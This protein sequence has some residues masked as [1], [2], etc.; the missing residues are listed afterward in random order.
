[1]KTDTITK[2]YISDTTVFADV[3]NYFIYGGE[4]VI[5]PEQLEERDPTEIALPY[6]ADG[7]AAP[8]QKFR[9]VQKL[10]AAMTDGSLEYV[11]YGI[12]AQSEIHYAAAVKNNLYDAIGYA[13]QVEE[14]ARSH[15]RAMKQAKADSG[16]EQQKPNAGE[17]LSGFWKTDRLIPSV[18]VML[19]FAPDAWDGPLSLFDMME[20][21]DPRILS[22]IDNY[23]VRLIAPAQMT[24]DEIMKFQSSLREVMF[25]IKYS[26]DR[27]NLNRILKANEKR[28]REVE[29]RAVDVIEAVTNSGIK[30]DESEVSV[31][32]CQAIQEIRK[33]ERRLG[34]QDGELKK[35]QE[36]AK[37]FYQLGVEVE[38]IAQGVGYAVEMVKEWLGIEL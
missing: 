12:E 38:K 17:F 22:F 25:F 8:I 32:M 7:V 27:E 3:F 10:Y 37:N 6:G 9:D 19:Y 1:M 18:T 34:E 14:A 2:D 36:A 29:R 35:A 13:G 24:D 5:R 21:K 16:T 28:F 4:Q 20:V 33:E 23:H 11:L 31:D 30:Y 15:R 26:K